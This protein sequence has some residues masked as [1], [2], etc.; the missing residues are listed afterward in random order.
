MIFKLLMTHR[1]K[2]LTDINGE[3][4]TLKNAQKRSNTC[5]TNRSQ[6]SQMLCNYTFKVIIK[7]VQFLC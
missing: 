6:M 4:G 5:T 3:N 7:Y 1:K 2:I